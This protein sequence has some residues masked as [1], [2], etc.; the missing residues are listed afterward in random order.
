M[1]FAFEIYEKHIGVH[2]SLRGRILNSGSVEPSHGA[3]HSIDRGSLYLHVSDPSD[4][5]SYE[6]QSRW[7]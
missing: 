1:R 4:V 7:L 6:Q 2:G 5:S 3:D